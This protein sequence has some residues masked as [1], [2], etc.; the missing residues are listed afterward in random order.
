[1]KTKLRPID[2]TIFMCLFVFAQEA[3][4]GISTA[5]FKNV[6][7]PHREKLSTLTSNTEDDKLENLTINGG[8]IS[9]SQ[10][11]FQEKFW[12][13]SFIMK[14]LFA[15]C[16]DLGISVAY[17]ATDWFSIDALLVNIEGDKQKK[18]GLNCRY[19]VTLT[20]TKGLQM[21]IYGGVN[22]SNEINKYNSVNTAAFLGYKCE[23]FTLGAEYNYIFNPIYQTEKDLFGYSAFMSV[24][25]D[26]YADLYFRF[27]DIFCK[28][29]EITNKIEHIAAIG[30]LFRLNEQVKLNPN[31][32]INLPETEGFNTNY[33]ACLNCYINL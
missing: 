33:F 29:E 1:M 24:K 12:S 3:Q 17:K 26:K 23:D 22:E 11:N 25:L 32:K 14:S 10:F 2:I 18:E 28:E 7:P 16:G 13:Y 15:S 9:T 31:F 30:F 21:R 27:D 20:P 4:A 19:G 8:I 5:D 6:L